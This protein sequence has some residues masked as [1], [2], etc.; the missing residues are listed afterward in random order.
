MS[1]VFLGPR[2]LGGGTSG[3]GY[4]LWGIKKLG[5]SVLIQ[6]GL[7]LCH[8]LGS[9]GR[10][11]HPRRKMA[12]GEDSIKRWIRIVY[13]I[14]KVPW[15]TNVYPTFSFSILRKG[16]WNQLFRQCWA[17]WGVAGWCANISSVFH[18]ATMGQLPLKLKDRYFED[19]VS[20]MKTLGIHRWE[21]H[22]NTPC[23]K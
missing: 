9:K 18:G 2:L 1:K 16:L 12:H 21:P 8:L 4:L 14:W 3:G 13:P 11:Q 19:F 7:P 22:S 17:G 15:Y 10:R 5:A 20:G 23:S 6:K